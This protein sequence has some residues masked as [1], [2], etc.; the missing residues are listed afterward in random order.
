MCINIAPKQFCNKTVPVSF[1][2]PNDLLPTPPGAASTY[3]LSLLIL[4]AFTDQE[5]SFHI[6]NFPG[7]CGNV[8]GEKMCHIFLILEIAY[9]PCDP[10][11]FDPV[12]SLLMYLIKGTHEVP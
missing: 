2:Q 11:R 7:Y 9:L 1:L 12:F 4:A 8:Q 6:Q 10:A 5:Q 3:Q